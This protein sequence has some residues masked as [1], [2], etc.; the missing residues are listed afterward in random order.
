MYVRYN[1]CVT[2]VRSVSSYDRS[3]PIHDYFPVLIFFLRE[4]VMTLLYLSIHFYLNFEYP[5]CADTYPVFVLRSILGKNL[6]K[7]CCV[8]RSTDCTMCLH[9]KNCAYAYI[10]E[11]ILPQNNAVQPGRDRAAHPFAFT[12]N[13][14]IERIGERIS[15]YDF[16][17]ALFGRALEYLPYIY[18]AFCRA[19]KDGLFKSRTPFAVYNVTAK[20]QSILEDSETIRTDI[21][22][23][24][25]NLTDYDTENA[26]N[27]D[28]DI[29]V[30]LRSPLR[31]KTAGRY[32]V[33]FDAKSFMLC[34]F[35]RMKTLCL[36]YG[37]GDSE[38]RYPA[39][40]MQ[41]SI[42]D[43]NIFWQDFSHFS[44]RQKYAMELGGALGTFRLH[45]RFTGLDRALLDFSKIANAGKNP[46][47]GLGQ[48]NFWKQY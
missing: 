39:D 21:T 45:G 31:F 48:I 32:S 34:L 16:T 36:L 38:M 35:R 18:A 14:K 29:L 22:P 47:F 27:S 19:G 46:N 2:Y 15:S 33:D 1:Q 41:L 26:D 24:R 37:D 12:Q 4:N 20:E 3:F 9:T 13:K 30:E 44:A 5:V 42:C 25:W 7:M 17:I 23:C 8:A 10:F 6:R 11:T 28:S 43:R 40:T